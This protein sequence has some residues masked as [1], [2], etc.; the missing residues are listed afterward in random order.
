MGVSARRW[1]S[2]CGE[3]RLPTRHPHLTSPSEEGEGYE[4]DRW[5]ILAAFRRGMLGGEPA[6][7]LSKGGQGEGSAAAGTVPGSDIGAR[8]GDPSPNPSP[9]GRGILTVQTGYMGNSLDRRHG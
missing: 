4:S 8:T 9:K 3:A 7:S 1:V 6:L 2:P 5:R